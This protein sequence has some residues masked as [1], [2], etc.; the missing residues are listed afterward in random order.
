MLTL[1]VP[2]EG[3]TTSATANYGGG[4]FPAACSDAAGA[5]GPDLVYSYTPT[6]DGAFV[7][8]L[9]SSESY[10]ALIWASTGTCSGSGSG[11]VAAADGYYGGASEQ[12][13]LDGVAGTTY[14]L[15]ADSWS[16][17]S[18]DRFGPFTIEIARFETCNPLTSNCGP[19]LGCYYYS[20][21]MFTCQP[22]GTVAVGESCAS[23]Q[24]VPGAVCMTDGTNETCGLLCPLS[25]SGGCTGSDACQDVGLPE[26]GVCGE[27]SALGQVCNPL[28]FTSCGAGLGCY[29]Y[30]DG[31]NWIYTCQSAG[32][33]PAGTNCEDA[34]VT[35]VPGTDCVGDYY[36]YSCQPFCNPTGAAPAC[37]SW[38]ECY[39]WGDGTG[40][41][42]D[43]Y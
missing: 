32:T 33:S 11:C 13:V 29:S 40:N 23:A 28:V 14:Y 38:Q 24:C 7:V 9:T 4:S 8:V 22:A 15:Y 26:I 27:V 43:S 19:D 5:P 41:C 30:N 37:S 42:F 36:E 25:G 3:D 16:A 21:N 20:D 17:T 18:E 1:G 10:D 34:G 2:V 6:Q 12:I 31:G 35:C 39:D